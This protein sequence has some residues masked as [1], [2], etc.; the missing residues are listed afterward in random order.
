MT[1]TLR[2]IKRS[3]G[4]EKWWA[5]GSGAGPILCGVAKDGYCAKVSL[6]KDLK[7]RK[8]A[9]HLGAGKRKGVS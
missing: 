5:A 1:R 9:S 7:G 8:E 3:K 2:T 4:T 6:N